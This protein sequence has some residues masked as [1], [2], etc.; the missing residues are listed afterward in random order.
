[1]DERVRV[2]LELVMKVCCQ[3][4][5]GLLGRT[6]YTMRNFLQSWKGDIMCTNHSPLTNIRHACRHQL[7][8]LT[9]SIVTLPKSSVD[10]CQELPGSVLDQT[11]L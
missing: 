11:T 2:E 3:R 9:W 5:V 1:M 10:F 6:L 4:E 8:N 7:D